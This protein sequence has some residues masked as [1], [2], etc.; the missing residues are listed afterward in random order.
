MKK[1]ERQ[2]YNWND[3]CCNMCVAHYNE[4]RPCVHFALLFLKQFVLQD[5]SIRNVH[6]KK[7]KKRK[8]KYCQKDEEEQKTCHAN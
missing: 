2:L 6:K 7:K 8:T 5:F 3:F 1:E 4:C